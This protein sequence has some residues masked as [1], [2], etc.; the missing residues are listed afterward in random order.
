MSHKK[1]SE[2][3]RFPDKASI[4][5]G[6]QYAIF[7]ALAYCLEYRENSSFIIFSDSKSALEAILNCKHTVFNHPIIM[8]ILNI[9]QALKS[10]NT[11]ITLGMDKS[12]CRHN[13][14]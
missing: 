4:Y 6:K 10:N 14:K 11:Q 1:I 12:S 8:K 9:Y 5:T 13:C 2:K 7:R 3:F